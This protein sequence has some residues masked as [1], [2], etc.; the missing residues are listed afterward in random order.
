MWVGLLAL[1]VFASI[2]I[3]IL[4]DYKRIDRVFHLDLTFF[5]LWIDDEF[6]FS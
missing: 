5:V 4:G 3:I 1:F 6:K 2:G